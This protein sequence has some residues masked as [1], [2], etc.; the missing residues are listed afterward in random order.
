M[1]TFQLSS[2]LLRRCLLLA[3]MGGFIVASPSG[4]YTR[5]A[6]ATSP[7][8]H[9]PVTAIVLDNKGGGWFATGTSDGTG[10]LNLMELKDG[11]PRFGL[12][13]TDPANANRGIK[14]MAM[15]ADGS[16]GWAVGVDDNKAGTPLLWRLTAGGWQPASH[17]LASTMELTDV[18]MSADGK[19]GWMVGRERKTGNPLLMRL[20][21]GSWVSVAAPP[22]AELARISIS[23]DGSRGWGIGASRRGPSV[24]LL[25]RLSGG[26]WSVADNSFPKG[27]SGK[28]VAAD[29][30]GNGWVIAGP[31]RE[32]SDPDMLLR[33][34]REGRV[35]S[36]SISAPH[37]GIAQAGRLV[38]SA[39]AV[40]G[41]GRGWAA[42]SVLLYETTRRESWSK[43]RVF[44]PVLVRLYGEGAL[45]LPLDATGIVGNSPYNNDKPNFDPTEL[46][47]GPD[48]AQIMLAGTYGFEQSNG[49]MYS[50][51]EPWPY[52]EPPSARPMQGAGRCLSATPYCLRGEFARA[53]EQ[54]GGA[55]RLGYPLTP[56]VTEDI[57]FRVGEQFQTKT[58]A[59]QYTDRARLEY[60]CGQN[61]C[62]VTLGHLGWEAAWQLWDRTDV[63][64]EASYRLWFEPVRFKDRISRR[65]FPQTGHNLGPPFLSYWNA[66]GGL[67]VHG[68]PISEPFHERL[69]DGKLLYVQYFER[70]RLEYHPEKKGTSNEVMMGNLGAEIFR[71]KYGISP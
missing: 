21:G 57:H 34:T 62:A 44:Q 40:G 54:F 1:F 5:A 22:D 55:S 36:V 65:W 46:A 42:G 70:S 20:R 14:Q 7:D 71:A 18:A 38:L 63:Q 3:L 32:G 51:H 2:V 11:R 50:L 68:Y 66:T 58:F 61:Q 48:G 39:L 43:E 67:G 17:K 27:Y 10:Y 8:E 29:D 30:A 28:Q 53:W 69:A 60:N 35:R 52:R 13:S 12:S 49:L 19:D 23:S 6:P 37:T 64:G 56:E 59:V 31:A 16:A 4:S 24:P 15:S 45:P 33:V 26:R 41:D 9:S 25:F 47:I